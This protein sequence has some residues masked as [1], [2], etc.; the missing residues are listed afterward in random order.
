MLNDITRSGLVALWFAAVAVG[1]A[2]VAAVGVSVGASTTALLLALSVVPPAIMLLVWR[3]A[4][5][6][7]VGE[8]L[9]AANHA[10]ENRS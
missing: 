6:Q 4:P 10:P 2:C 1:L 7:T 5:P 8:I 9:Y 3:G